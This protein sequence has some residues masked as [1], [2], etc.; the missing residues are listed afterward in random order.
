MAVNFLHGVETIELRKGTRPFRAVKTAVVFLVG[1]APMGPVNEPT[2]VL[3]DVDAAQF[4]PE[5][6]NFTIP[7]ALADII[8]EG[9]GAI[10]VVNVCNPAEHKTAVTAEARTFNDKNRITLAHPH[11]S[12]VVIKNTAGTTTYILD[13]DYKIVDAAT[14]TLE[15]L[16]TGAITAGQAIKADYEYVDPTEVV[17][18]DII[19]TTSVGGVRSGLQL[20]KETYSRFG[21]KPKL[22]LAPV[23][24]TQASVVAEMAALLP[25]QKALALVDAPIGTT[26]AQAIS[27]RGPSGA[28][29]FNVSNDRLVL[30]F[31]HI[32]TLNKTSNEVELRPLSSVL[33]GVI[34]RVDNELGYW[35][36]PSNKVINGITGVERA[37]SAD[38]TDASSETNVLN[39]NGIVTVYN[40]FGTGYRT[41][42]NRSSAWPSDADPTNFIAC[43]RIK[44]VLHETI[45]F[46][47]LPFI[48]EPITDALIDAILASCNAF[49]RTLIG[50]GAL[51]DG[52]VTYNPNKNPPTEIALGHLTFDVTF[53]TSNPAE[54]I[55]FE[56]FHDINLLAG[57]GAAA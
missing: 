36:S 29:N 41:W 23:F 50:R 31:P 2:L 10:V 8:K 43:R 11:V 49:V 9:Y 20:A 3:G 35:Y 30:C 42:G 55:T 47:I 46:N 21:F 1:T 13:T 18:S 17:N 57:L 4:G 32:K 53:A 54:R 45:E 56:S 40:N 38:Y 37:L 14:G 5:S 33:A 16:T 44:D 52:F 19:G 39:E 27:G 22:F 48:D 12:S 25:Q 15:R 51:V 6:P 24:S 34:C 7:Q 28:I 26:F